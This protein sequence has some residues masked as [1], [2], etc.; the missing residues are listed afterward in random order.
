MKKSVIILA[1]FCLVGPTGKALAVITNVPANFYADIGFEFS[2]ERA[3][4]DTA[5]LY[6]ADDWL[7][8][9]I[10]DFGYYDPFDQIWKPCVII[11]PHWTLEDYSMTS[12]MYYFGAPGNPFDAYVELGWDDT[13]LVNK[14]GYDVAL[15]TIYTTTPYDLRLNVAGMTQSVTPIDTGYTTQDFGGVS[16]WAVTLAKLDLSDFGMAPGDSVS[17][18]QI[19]MVQDSI[20]GAR[21]FLA[22]VGYMHVIPAP[23]ALLLGSI[24]IG[25]VGYLRKRR[26]L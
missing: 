26:A 6:A 9:G 20:T 16:T 4:A 22:L 15:F 13:S 25:F 24:G 2:D 21:P 7:F 18:I 17:S 19:D 11:P 5:Q 1:V 3:F 14:P 8:E 23:G 12:Y 10:D